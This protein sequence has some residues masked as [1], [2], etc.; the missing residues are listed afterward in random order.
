M[1]VIMTNLNGDVLICA[2]E[3]AE[4]IKL[5][6]AFDIFNNGF[7]TAPKGEC[8]KMCFTVKAR[9]GMFPQPSDE[10]E[11]AFYKKAEYLLDSHLHK[12]GLT[13]QEVR[14]FKMGF[15]MEGQCI[16]YKTIEFLLMIQKADPEGYNA[17]PENEFDFQTPKESV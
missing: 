2:P 1:R 5:K 6:Q 15:N 7:E 8:T 10:R 12:E 16:K 17:I 4:E 3:Q 9:P 14:R 13:E 11:A